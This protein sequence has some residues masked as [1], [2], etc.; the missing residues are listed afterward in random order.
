M[1]R[2]F[3]QIKS[4]IFDLNWVTFYLIFGRCLFGFCT[5]FNLFG[6]FAFWGSLDLISFLCICFCLRF[7]FFIFDFA[8]TTGKHKLDA[9]DKDLLR[10][11]RIYLY[12]DGIRVYPYGDP[13]DDWLLIDV[14]RGTVKAGEFVSN[15]QVVGQVRITQAANPGLRDK[16]S[17]EGLVETGN[18]TSD[19]RALLQIFL[20]WVRK[21]PYAQY[22]IKAETIAVHRQM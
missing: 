2:L 8:A 16:T 22:K 9:A 11:H 4:F 21:R 13:D 5:C 10:Q 1:L 7:E 6:L 14:R 17:R 19:F 12:R 18:P 15:D 20:A 3:I